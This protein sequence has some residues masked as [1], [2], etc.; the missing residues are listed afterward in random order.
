[1]DAQ[2]RAVLE[3]AI[4]PLS[5]PAPGPD[6]E[7]DVRPVGRRRGEALIEVCRRA[8]AA[9]GQVP[10]STKAQLYITMTLDDL[11]NTTGAGCTLG[12]LDSGGLLGPE[13]VRRMACDAQ[14]HLVSAST[15]A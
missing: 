1:M 3:A 9:G 12:S 13:T 2:G 15:A 10:T 4:G 7:H 6:G 11:R 8:T 5:A 14:C